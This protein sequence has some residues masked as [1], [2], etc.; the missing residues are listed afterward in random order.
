MKTLTTALVAITLVLLL[1][2]QAAAASPRAALR[3]SVPPW[4]TPAAQVST[5]SPNAPVNFRVYL[6]L[7][8]GAQA[9]AAAV[10]DPRSKSYGRYLSPAGF[11]ARYAPTAAAVNAVSSWLQSEGLTVGYVPSNNHYVAAEGTVAQV[12][13]AF[14]TTLNLYAVNGQ[15]LRAPA[16]ELQ[17]PAGLAGTIAGVLGVDQ[18]ESLFR[19]FA[20]SR[21]DK[22]AL[23]PTVGVVLALYGSAVAW[24]TERGGRGSG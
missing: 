19:T 1:P 3:G 9:A 5:G 12:A 7:Q 11:N 4:A 20:S 18:T 13:A 17:I 8:D 10:S 15:T 14:G 16:S 23:P 22:W 6:S 2:L 24:A 21:T